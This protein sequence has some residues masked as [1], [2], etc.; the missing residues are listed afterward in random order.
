M[1]RKGESGK[2]GRSAWSAASRGEPC[3]MAGAV[4]PCRIGSV[5]EHCYNCSRKNRGRSSPGTCQAVGR[6]ERANAIVRHRPRHHQLAHH[7]V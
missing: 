4:M 7:S 5:A 6:G 1:P 3:R 2:V